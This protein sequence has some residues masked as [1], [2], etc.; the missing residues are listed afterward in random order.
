MLPTKLIAVSALA[1]VALGDI[2][3]AR[4]VV[5]YDNTNFGGA[6]KAFNAPYDSTCYNIW[7]WLQ[8][9]GGV[10]QVD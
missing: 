3:G 10:R 7:D 4:T 6:S 2:A 5:L 1:V 9:Q 8:R